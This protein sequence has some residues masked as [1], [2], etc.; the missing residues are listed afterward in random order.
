MTQKWVVQIKEVRTG[1]VLK[2]FEPCHERKA[3]RVLN[4]ALIN[5]G[6][7]FVATMVPA[8]ES[9]ISEEVK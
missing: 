2:E 9:A 5:L 6:E 3:E 7:A 8:D 1:R 4:G